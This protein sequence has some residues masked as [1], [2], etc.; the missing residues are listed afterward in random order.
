MTFP[1]L[2]ESGE[3]IVSALSK[4]SGDER[5]SM[6]KVKGNRMPVVQE[7]LE[8]NTSINSANT[9]TD[10]LEVSLSEGTY[11]IQSR[12]VIDND[13]SSTSTFASRLL[14]V[15]E[16]EV[17]GSSMVLTENGPSTN[18]NQINIS[19]VIAVDANTTV[20]LQCWVDD[21]TSCEVKESIFPGAEKCTTLLVMHLLG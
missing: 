21:N 19:R 7:I 17:L 13:A 11:F 16:D 12:A 14:D 5:L 1:S 9:W 15:E 6:T 3:A 18:T 10:V 2:S 4:L 8:S 20:K